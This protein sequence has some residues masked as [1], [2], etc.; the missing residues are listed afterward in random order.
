[1][2][3]ASL[4][5][6]LEDGNNAEAVAGIIFQA[7]TDKVPHFRYQVNEEQEALVASVLKDPHGIN[8]P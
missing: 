5:Y 3:A 1:M 2:L 8:L 4:P 7:A 6:E